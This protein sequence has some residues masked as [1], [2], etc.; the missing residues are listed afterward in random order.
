M[1]GIALDS[2]ELALTIL[3]EDLPGWT[4]SWHRN[5][6]IWEVRTPRGQ[7]IASDRSP[8]DAVATSLTRFRL[9]KA[10]A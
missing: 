3:A 4:L 7:V 5:L 10:V 6:G 8:L 1:D 9:E 2:A